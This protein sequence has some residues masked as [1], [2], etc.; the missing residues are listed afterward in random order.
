MSSPQPFSNP[1]AGN[2]M[3]K[4]GVMQGNHFQL[5]G[6]LLGA[7]ALNPYHRHDSSPRG[8]MIANHLGQSLVVKGATERMVQTGYE[9]E[10]GKYTF[11]VS[12]PCNA[13]IVEIIPRYRVGGP[14]STDAINY[15]PQTIVI[16]EDQDT[17][18]LGMLSLTDYCSNH[19]YFGF[20]FDDGPGMQ[21][22]YP[23]AT[24]PKGTVFKRS[25]NVTNEGGYKIGLEANICYATLPATSE[26]GVLISDAL[27]P[28]LGIHTYENRVV[29]W[30]D[31]KFALNL[32]G[33]EN[34]YKPFPDIGERIREDGVLM[35]LRP[36]GPEELA[37]VERSVRST[38]EVDYTFDNTVYVNGPGGRVVDIK[39]HHDFHSYNHAERHM[40]KQAQKYD[41]ERRIFYGRIVD[42]WK[43]YNRLRNGNLQI[44]PELSRMVVEAQSVASQGEGQ[45][46][47]MLYRQIPLDDYRVEFVIEYDIVPGIGFKITDLH[48]GKGVICQVAKAEDMPVDQDGNR[49]DIVMD[50]NSTIS[51]MNLGRL[52]EQYI[53]A[54]SRDVHKAVCAMLKCTPFE[55]ED[56][57]LMKIQGGSNADLQQA[58]NHLLGYYKITSPHMYE[59]HTTGKI[60]EDT[61][62]YM[63][64]IVNRGV[65][66]YVPP[67]NPVES[68]DMVL[69]L[70]ANYRPTYGPIT[71]RGNSG[72]LVTTKDNVRIGSMYVVLLE[73]I[74]D[75]W[76]AVS[77]GK[78]QHFGVLSQLTKVD[79]YA[80]PARNQAVR[81]AGEAEV[82]I[83]I[84]YIGELFMAEMM[85][86]NNNP[87]TH[88]AIVSNILKAAKPS[89]IDNLIDRRMHPYGGAKP[90]QLISHIIECG[91][92][93]FQYAPY[94]PPL[95]SAV[96][97]SASLAGTPALV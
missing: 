81:G 60:E 70:E 83:F 10:Y 78:L 88:K 35:A 95:Q 6:S 22:L 44:T 13:Q 72:R 52:Y 89:N 24:I 14:G 15:N 80:K 66:L 5:H 96:Q 30:G 12:M 47:G 54:A 27:L 29:E 77:S 2:Y 19:Q 86:R 90:V 37:I 85:D 33:D 63:S 79:K 43:K 31:K 93:R 74:G 42:V 39:I 73:K 16:Y 91:G 4:A 94:V 68:E 9:R 25:P 55:A 1:L 18:V 7:N 45:R 75:D 82:R 49:A 34:N 58:Y 59:W 84:S 40:D 17:K 71:Y 21:H 20:Q 56:M 28:R 62:V 32:Y 46:V 36:Y 8:A 69:A 50:P 65:T 26:D 92:A 51:R 3:Q 76:S 61:A 48:G 57:A 53:N 64:E 41:R 23:R 38:M 67:D 87:Q 11:G 97:L